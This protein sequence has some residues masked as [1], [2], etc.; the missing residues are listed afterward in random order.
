[1]SLITRTIRLILNLAFMWIVYMIGYLTWTRVNKLAEDDFD[2]IVGGSDDSPVEF[3]DIMDAIFYYWQK[4]H[5]GTIPMKGLLIME[6]IES[7]PNKGGRSLRFQTSYPIS[8]WDVL[9]LIE[10]V[11]SQINASEFVEQL[12]G[13]E[14]IDDED[15]E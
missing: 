2:K 5:P 7:D 12:T 3:E 15:D 11:K 4:F 1:M 8:S 6:S 10:S 13:G 9:G 14:P